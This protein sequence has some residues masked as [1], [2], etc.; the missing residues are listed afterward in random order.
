MAVAHRDVRHLPGLGRLPHVGAARPGM[1]GSTM[2]CV[3]CDRAILGEAIVVA[4]GHSASGARPDSYAHQVTDPE[5]TG[6][7]AAPSIL[8]RQLD[9]MPPPG[10]R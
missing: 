8:H 10:R 2:I 7:R 3:Y 5:C 4:E 1:E 9:E 6:R